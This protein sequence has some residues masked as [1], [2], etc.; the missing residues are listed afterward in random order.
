LGG[1]IRGV[2]GW[3][4]DPFSP[5]PPSRNPKPFPEIGTGPG[6]FSIG[7]PVDLKTIIWSS[8]IG[9]PVIHRR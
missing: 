3:V 4:I 7:C 2:Y 1:S 8:H 6:F 9:L 5:K